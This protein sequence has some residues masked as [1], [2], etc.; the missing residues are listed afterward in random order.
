ML[1]CW[2]VRAVQ[3]LVGRSVR[4]LYVSCLVSKIFQTFFPEV[5]QHEGYGAIGSL[6]RTC[7]HLV[8]L[9]SFSRKRPRRVPSKKALP[10]KTV[11]K[12][13]HQTSPKVLLK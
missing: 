11:F 13:C 8:L 1:A 4:N 12:D 3:M 5:V 2:R 6:F 10:L 7:C 9:G